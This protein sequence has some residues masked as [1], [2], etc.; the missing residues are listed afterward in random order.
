[1]EK[2]INRGFENVASFRVFCFVLFF[3]STC[4]SQSLI[5]NSVLLVLRVLLRVRML[6]YLR[7]EVIGD[8]AE[9][10]LDGADSSV[11][12]IWI[13]QPFHAEVPAD[14]WDSE[15]DKSLLIGVF[16]HGYEKYNSMRADPALCFLERVGMPDAKAIA[17]EQRGSDMMADGAEGEDEDPEYKPLR[18]PFKDDMDDF[19]N[20]PLDDKDEGVEG[21]NEAKSDENSQRAPASNERLYWPAASALTA[22]LRRLITAYQRSNRREQL[23]QEALNRPDGRRRRRREF[24]PSVGMVTETGGAA[25]YIQDGAGMFMAEGSPYLA[26][27]SA[28]FAK[29]GQF[30]PEASPVLNASSLVSEGA[31][32]YKERRQRWTRREEA[33]FYRVVST[34]GVV[35]DTKRQK[36][37]WTQFRA[38]ARLDK[39][40]D[41]S[42]EKYY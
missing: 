37:D 40:T 5:A 4:T 1:M 41:E 21:E 11:L 24:L 29:G 36:F 39:K 3:F 23:R 22:R 28:Y 17:A 10:I 9:R 8:Q 32:Y 14:W 33:D 18:M 19:T 12:D 6:Y 42:L 7:Q 27:G 2:A 16:K 31:M 25:T 30:M 35:F 38:F 26:K 15:A 20:S 34:F 13:P